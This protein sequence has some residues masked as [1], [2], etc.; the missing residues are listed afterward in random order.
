MRRRIRAVV[1]LEAMISVFLLFLAGM[2][3]LGTLQTSDRA[4]TE[5]TQARIAL[6]LAREGLELVRAGT[7]VPTAGTQALTP[8]SVPVGRVSI[9]FT[10]QIVGLLQ[11]NV[12]LIRS[13]VLWSEGPRS[14][15]VE[16]KTY[17]SQ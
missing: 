6:R 17:V 7:V 10:Q 3:M 13:Q 12:W 9:S 1:M 14:H 16:L 2:T 4:Y 11:G 8:V 5:A 15:V